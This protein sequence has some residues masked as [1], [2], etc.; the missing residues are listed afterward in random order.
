MDYRTIFFPSL[1]SNEKYIPCKVF[2]DPSSI[3]I[4]G[5]EPRARHSTK[6]LEQIIIQ[7]LDKVETPSW[8]KI[9]F[10]LRQ[11]KTIQIKGSKIKAT[12]L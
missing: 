8:K 5:E 12:S 2:L 1:F 7:W 9:F 11:L 4:Y 3:I 6:F 10:Y